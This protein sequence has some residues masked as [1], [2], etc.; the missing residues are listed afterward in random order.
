MEKGHF[1]INLVVICLLLSVLFVA[2]NNN[3]NPPHEH[4]YEEAWK[5][6]D[7]T[8]HGKNAICEHTDEVLKEEHA[9]ELTSTEMATT[10]A[11]GKKIFTCSECNHTKEEPIPMLP[12]IQLAP[13]FIKDK[14]YDKTEI[15]IDISQIIKTETGEPI[16]AN[17]FESILFKLK[18][19]ADDKYTENHPVNAGEYTVKVTIKGSEEHA[20]IELTKDFTIKA[21]TLNG[22]YSSGKSFTYNGNEH[23]IPKLSLSDT[24]FGEILPKDSITFSNIKFNKDAEENKAALAYTIDNPNYIAKPDEFKITATISPIE[25]KSTIN[26]SREYNGDSTIEYD[27]WKLIDEVL[28]NDKS[29][30][31]LDIIM[32]ES[33]CSASSITD[34][35]FNTDNYIIDE[36]L[37]NA[38]ITKKEL[39]LRAPKQFH[40]DGTVER[41]LRQYEVTSLSVLQKR[42]FGIILGL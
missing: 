13:D 7:D 40:Y 37:I 12:K 33:G 31:A 21:K 11:A 22:T 34:Y 6:L 5:K 30:L 42:E 32:N 8:H 10:E 18:G 19:N 28:T 25:I 4:V 14:V 29:T 36:S 16:D 24:V 27:D 23:I 9:W 35:Y 15:S 26:A 20:K 38:S 3:S 1:K 17:E 2:C 39:K 41:T